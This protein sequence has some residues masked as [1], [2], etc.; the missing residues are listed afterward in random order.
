MATVLSL[1]SADPVPQL[2]L[3]FLF[4]VFVPVHSLDRNMSGGKKQKTNKQTNKQ[5]KKTRTKQNK[6]FEMGGWFHPSTRG[7]AYLLEVV[8]TGS[9]IPVGSREPQ[10]SLVSGTLQWLS[11]IPHPPC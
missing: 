10:V 5:K 8:A 2:A 3:Q 1:V 4:Y 6:T 11:S 9:I 7:H